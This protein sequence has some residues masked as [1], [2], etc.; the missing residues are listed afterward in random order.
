MPAHFVFGTIMGYFYGKYLV[1]GEKKWRRVAFWLPVAYHTITNTLVGIPYAS[2]VVVIS[3]VVMG[4]VMVVLIL[5]WQ[6]NKTLDVPVRQ[7]A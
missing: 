3:H 1:T 7:G 2:L 5:R 6:R 4:I